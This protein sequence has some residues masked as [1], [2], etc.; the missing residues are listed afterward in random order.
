M[1]THHKLLDEGEL[2]HQVWHGDDAEV[3]VR[4]QVKGLREEVNRPG[5]EERRDSHSDTDTGVR[6]ED[7]VL[8]CIYNNI[9]IYKIIIPNFS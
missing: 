8:Y 7:S 3:S 1:D 6:A 2:R 4:E 9:Y 5:G